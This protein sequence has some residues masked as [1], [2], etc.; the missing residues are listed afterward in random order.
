MTG[1]MFAHIS[2]QRAD[3]PATVGCGLN[4]NDLVTVEQPCDGPSLL[5]L[6]LTG[7]KTAAEETRSPRDGTRVCV[8]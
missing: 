3:Q 6:A 8:R 7:D 4:Q 2:A 1:V 5:A